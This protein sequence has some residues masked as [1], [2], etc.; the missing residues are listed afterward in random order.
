MVAGKEPAAGTK[1]VVVVP[2]ELV[3]A[4][5]RCSSAA[6]AAVSPRSA[7]LGRIWRV[8]GGSWRRLC[9]D[10]GGGAAAVRRRQ[11][12][13]LATATA[14]AVVGSCGVGW[15]WRQW[16]TWHRAAASRM[17]VKGDGTAAGC[18]CGGWSRWQRRRRLF[19]EAVVTSAARRG[20]RRRGS[21]ALGS[22]GCSGGDRVYSHWRH[23]GLKRLAEGVGGDY[24]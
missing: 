9:G 5:A 11:Q 17:L 15:R 16:H 12:R 23:G 3:V 19:V 14:V 24:I 2:C 18:G 22:S 1:M 21:W 8:A 10:D 13:Q 4:T 20:W 6:A 7:P